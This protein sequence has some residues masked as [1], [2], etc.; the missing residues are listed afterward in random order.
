MVDVSRLAARAL[1]QKRT[2]GVRVLN[3]GFL[4][5]PSGDGGRPDFGAMFEALWHA[6]H[7]QLP[8][9]GI[10]VETDLLPPLENPPAGETIEAARQAFHE[11]VE[12]SQFN[13]DLFEKLFLFLFQAIMSAASLKDEVSAEEKKATTAFMRS[14]VFELFTEPAIKI[15][16]RLISFF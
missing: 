7:G 12:E 15:T 13:E 8:P 2:P 6:D 9:K 16:K 11:I 4:E 3:S 1:I 5:A 10:F 14:V